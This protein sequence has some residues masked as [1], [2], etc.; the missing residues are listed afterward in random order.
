MAALTVAKPLQPPAT[1]PSIGPV[2]ATF[3][4]PDK[5]G[6]DAG[7]IVVCYRGDL[8]EDE[9]AWSTHVAYTGDEGKHWS[10]SWGHYDLSADEVKADFFERIERGY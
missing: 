2:Y 6:Y 8:E 10:A 9:K 1:L 5:E 7:F 3:R 4:L